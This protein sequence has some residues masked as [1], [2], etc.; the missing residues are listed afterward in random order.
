LIISAKNSI[1][2]AMEAGW[3][4]RAKEKIEQINSLKITSNNKCLTGSA[5]DKILEFAETNKID[6][7][8]MGSRRLKGVSKIKALGSVARKVSEDANC[9]VLLIH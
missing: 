1:G 3:N 4:K 5:A 7:I 2:R 8:V 9:P 6:M